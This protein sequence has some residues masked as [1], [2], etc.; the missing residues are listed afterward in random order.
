VTVPPV[1]FSVK[2]KSPSILPPKLMIFAAPL[3][4]TVVFPVRR[5]GP[6]TLS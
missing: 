2:A 4:S 5:V 3:V 6:A 1:A